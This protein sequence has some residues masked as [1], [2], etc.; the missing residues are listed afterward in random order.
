MTMTRRIA[1][2]LTCILS[3]CLHTSV[4][5]A[6]SPVPSAATARIIPAAPEL[7]ARAWILI[8]ARTGHVITEH[9]ADHQEA[10][11]SL[12]KMLTTYIASE[13]LKAGE[14][15]W[16]DMVPISEKAWRTGGSKM[17]VKVGTKVSLKDLMLGI[18]VDSG[19]DA[20]VAL[21]QYIAGSEDA[22]A[23]LM[24]QTAASLGMS[25]SHFV[26]ATGLPVEGH[27][28]TPRDLA[29]LARAIIYNHPEDY[30]LYSEKDFTYNGIHQ[31]NRNTL[32]WRDPDVDGIKTGHTEQAGY[33]LVASAKTDG[34]RLI[35]VVMGTPTNEARLSES[36][37]LLTY[38]FRFFQTAKSYAAKTTLMEHKVWMGNVDKVKLG[39]ADD[40]YLT[41]PR[42]AAKDVQAELQV[43]DLIK[44]PIIKGQQ[45]GTIKL[46][47]DGNTLA[48]RPLVA[49]TSV[50]EG[51]LFKRLWD[52]ILLTVK[53]WFHH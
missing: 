22:F 45:L 30:K 37:K 12:T 15:H 46:T 39:N 50:D 27:Y 26:N 14:L 48:T 42:G 8:D 11:A 38:G 9:N 36:Q 18:I 20:A 19:N 24:N 23:D 16:D 6:T 52:W 51:G 49:L 10:P 5:A 1:F 2:L 13:R 43:Q 28:S 53:G 41:I 44:A 21:S 25:H 32:L 7:N 35:S 3:F 17:F 34:T 31:A 29:T 4:R 40:I 33:C 47:L